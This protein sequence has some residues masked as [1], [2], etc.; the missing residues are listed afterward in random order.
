MAM[1]D[2]EAHKIIRDM[3][4]KE[5]RNA[6][7]LGERLQQETAEYQREPAE[8]TAAIIQRIERQHKESVRKAEALAIA[9]SKF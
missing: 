6:H 9:V 8:D 7:T 1:T 5:V 2:N 4:D 3:L